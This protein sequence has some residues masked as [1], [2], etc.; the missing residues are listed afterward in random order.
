M[1][2]Q[3]FNYSVRPVSSSDGP[4]EGQHDHNDQGWSP[5]VRARFPWMG[6]GALLTVLLCAGGSI[7]VLVTSNGK[8]QNDWPE[9]IA[10]NVLLNVMTSIANICFAIAIGMSLLQK[11]N[12]PQRWLIVIGNGIAIAWWRKALAGSSIQDLHR[13]WSYST[14][15]SQIIFSLKGFNVIALAALTAKL[16]IIDS[17]LMQ[18]ATTTETRTDPPIQ[19]YNISGFAN[20]TLGLTG[21]VSGHQGCS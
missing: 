10:P 2:K 13:S 11:D 21:Q 18:R 19:V 12:V 7:A 14:S 16:T 20:E 15:L 5:G 1:E 17:T 3:E 6:F 4:S 8:S 9:E